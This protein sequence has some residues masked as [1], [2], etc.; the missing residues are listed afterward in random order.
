MK[1]QWQV[2]RRLIERDDGERRWD[3]AF[4]F[5]LRYVQERAASDELF[6]R[7]REELTDEDCSLR[8]CLD[9]SPAATSND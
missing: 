7:P 1:T 4:Q 3:Y 8:T 9:R 2:H 5:L 6:S